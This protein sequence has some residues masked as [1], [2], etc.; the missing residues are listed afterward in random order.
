M[1]FSEMDLSGRALNLA[2][3]EYMGD[4]NLV[5]T[6]LE[7]YRK[8]TADEIR[9]QALTMFRKTNCSVLHYLSKSSKN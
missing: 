2:V 7:L 8:V 5:N 4:A 3:A 1:E 6:E 9:V